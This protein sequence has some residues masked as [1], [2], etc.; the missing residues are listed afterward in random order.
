[1]SLQ[2]KLD[3]FKAHW[4]SK[5]APADAV[6]ALHRQTDELIASGQAD[7]ALKAGDRAPEFTL[8]DSDGNPVSSTALLAKGPL[9]V[10]FYRGVWCP[11][12][13]IDLQALEEAVGGIRDLGAT[14]VAVSQQTATFSR[15]AQRDNHLS[16]PILSDT[17]GELADA[18]GLRYA[19]PQYLIDVYSGFKLDLAEINGEPSWTLP[20]PG[21]YVIAQDGV[22]VYAEVNPDYTTRPDPSELIP[23]LESLRYGVTA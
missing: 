3:T 21:R 2:E 14:L 6:A 20:I 23:V 15:K 12:C 10:T 19:M 22:I 5:V 18:F 11:Y 8:L 17:H 7:R 16:F 13:N 4:E 1:M 9:V